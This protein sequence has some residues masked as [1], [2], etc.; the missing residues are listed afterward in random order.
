MTKRERL[1][2]AVQGKPV[3]RTPTGFWLHFPKEAF[4]GKAAVDAHLDFFE[5]TDTDIMKIM[6]ESLV[7]AFPIEKPSD[8]R[9]VMPLRRDARFVTDALDVTKGVL[10]KVGGKG[11]VLLTVHGLIASMWHTRGGPDG[12]EAGRKMLARHYHLRPGFVIDALRTLSEGLTRFVEEA[13]KTGIDGI[14]YAAL[15]GERGLFD[16]ETFEYIIKPL[17]LQILDAA[18]NAP[19][20]NVLHLCKDNLDLS[21]YIGYPGA[22]VNW[23]THEGN[24]SLEEG[25]NIFRTRT[26]LGGFD[27]RAGVLVD[28]DKKTIAAETKALIARM[29]AIN[30]P[31]ILGADCTLPTDIDYSRIRAAV[32]AAHGA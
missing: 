6:N 28:G 30:T 12:Y 27:D 10:D 21:R 2:A 26:L 17:E 29:K 7:P 31:F 15:G 9:E 24:P 5:K 18:K 3:D 19:T 23:A 32:D 25:H 16:D 1:L 13:M 8:W 4:F 11:V 22:V 14:Y 20:F